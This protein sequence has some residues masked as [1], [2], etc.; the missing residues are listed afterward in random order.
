MKLKCKNYKIVIILLLFPFGVFIALDLL[1][2]RRS[3]IA[4]AVLTGFACV[5]IL[6][7][8][9]FMTSD[10]A[11]IL[12]K[13]WEYT[14]PGGFEKDFISSEIS[15]SERPESTDNST[16]S[17]T[18]AETSS[19][20]SE[21]SKSSA[22]TKNSA[23]NKTKPKT[24]KPSAAS[25][26]KTK[27]ITTTPKKTTEPVTSTAKRPTIYLSDSSI[28]YTD[29]G[30]KYIHTDKDCPNLKGT[31]VIFTFKDLYK[32]CHNYCQECASTVLY[33]PNED[34]Y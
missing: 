24:K 1:L 22:A 16:T 8:I 28:V 30:C 7:F 15:T 12:A 10:S 2:S 6:T 26:T 25:A 34:K 33:L 27:K 17:V 11:D 19:G 21:T 20:T 23:V 3:K 32:K 14:Y 29:A 13:D 9:P 18:S 5:F 31:M 4:I